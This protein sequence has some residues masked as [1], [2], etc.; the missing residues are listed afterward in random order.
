MKSGSFMA[1]LIFSVVQH[2]GAWTVEHEGAR[3]NR[4]PEKAVAIA[5]AHKLARAAITVGRAV[6]VRIEGETGYF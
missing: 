4:S 5:S 3:S 1:P 2:D 6:Q